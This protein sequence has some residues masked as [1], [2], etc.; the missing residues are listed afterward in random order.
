M[1][2]LDNSGI[3][4]I[5]QIAYNDKPKIDRMWQDNRLREII[6][7]KLAEMEKESNVSTSPVELIVIAEHLSRCIRMIF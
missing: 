5:A 1:I 7:D 2:H 4:N 3:H 6:Q